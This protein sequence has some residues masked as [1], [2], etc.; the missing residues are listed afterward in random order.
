MIRCALAAIALV[1][2]SAAS[3]DGPPSGIASA[4]PGTN[5][6]RSS[7]PF[8]EIVSGGVPRDG[9]P[10]ITDPKMAPASTTAGLDP[11][12]PVM[13]V[14]LPGAEARAYPIRYLTW[15]EIVNDAVGGVPIAVTFC[16]LCNSGLVFDR[17]HGGRVLEFGVSGLLRFSDMIMYD[18]QTMSWWQQFTGEAIVGELTGAR[19]DQIVAWMEPWSAFAARNPAG[20][21]MAQPSGHA[22]PY[23]V[24]PYAGY[25]SAAQPFLYSGEDPPHGVAPLARVLRVGDRAWPLER[26]AESG[27]IEEAG[28]SIRW[29]AGMA[30]A[31]DTRRIGEGRDV[32]SIRVRDTATGADVAHEVV[33]AFAF[34]AF[35]PDGEWMLG[36]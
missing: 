14:E 17:R 23:G 28:L 18:R 20:L 2:A 16:P 35:S 19:L 13:T 8:S 25:D 10:A 6:D 5:F 21:V 26:L 12:E 31:L 4:W 22:R 7:A 34:H 30:S 15:H 9:I 11:R 27:E 32:G 3:A 29:E 1:A 33:F 24:N 36:P